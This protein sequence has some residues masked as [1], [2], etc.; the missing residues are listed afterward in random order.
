MS[1]EELSLTGEQVDLSHYVTDEGGIWSL[2]QLE[3]VRG[4]NS[5]EYAPGLSGKNTPSTELSKHSIVTAKRSST[6]LE[7]GSTPDRWPGIGVSDTIWLW[8]IRRVS[9]PT[10]SF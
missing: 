1:E 8:S 3:K 5:I 7:L 10:T 6:V 9:P 4:W 2:R